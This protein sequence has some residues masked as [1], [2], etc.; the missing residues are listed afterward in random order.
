MTVKHDTYDIYDLALGVYPED[1]YTIYNIEIVDADK[2][3]VR[4]DWEI[5]YDDEQN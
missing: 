1:Q 5:K 3:L 2:G 4:V